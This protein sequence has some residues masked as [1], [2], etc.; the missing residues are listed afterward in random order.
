M[1]VL[2]TRPA[3]DSMNTAR[4]LTALGHHAIVAPLFEP[5]LLDGPEPALEDIQAILVTSGNGIRALAHRSGRRDIPVFAVGTRTAVA[6]REAG[7]NLVADAR[8]DAEA[9]AA[10]ASARLQPKS[11]PVLHAAG[12]NSPLELARSLT[13]QGFEIRRCVLY[14]LVEVEELPAAAA[15]A[16]RGD[17]LDAVLVFSPRSARLLKNCI[18]GAGL[19]S[20]CKRLLA[21]CISVHAANGLDGLVFHEVRIASRPNETSLLALLQEPVCFP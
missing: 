17:R 15:I 2:V 13:R 16:L 10:L 12:E 1:R 9:L 20:A 19:A 11:G 14:R 21:C 7:F 6:A 4:E 8:G 3:D 5:R 18:R